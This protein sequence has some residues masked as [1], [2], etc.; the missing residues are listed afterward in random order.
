MIGLSHIL[1]DR[2]NIYEVGSEYEAVVTCEIVYEMHVTQ[3][4]QTPSLL[5]SEH[6]NSSDV[7]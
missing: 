2:P 1:F 7:G 6:T 3:L 5:I 4:L